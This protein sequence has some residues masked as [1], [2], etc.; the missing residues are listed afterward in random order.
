[1]EMHLP[2]L[3][4]VPLVR[5]WEVRQMLVGHTSLVVQVGL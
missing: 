4:L 5:M 3:L 2:R 1:M